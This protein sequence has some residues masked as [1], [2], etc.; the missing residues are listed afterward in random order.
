MSLLK[1][2][3]KNKEWFFSGIG[4]TVF[5]TI[6]QS[7][8]KISSFTYN[9]SIIIFSI[10]F[11]FVLKKILDIYKKRRLLQIYCSIIIN[12][13]NQIDTYRSVL[14][15]PFVLDLKKNY[16][17]LQFIPCISYNK[18]SVIKSKNIWSI[19]FE[20]NDHSARGLTIIGSPGSGK[21]SL[22]K[23]IALSVIENKSISNYR[24]P[25]LLDLY[26]YKDFILKGKTVDKIIYNYF[27][28][29]NIYPTF[30][31]D[32]KWFYNN[33][34]QG[35]CIVLIDGLDQIESINERKKIST[36]IDNQILNYSKSKFIITSRSNTYNDSILNNAFVYEIKQL[37]IANINQIIANWFDTYNNY[38]F[39]G[40]YI[41]NIL[42]KYSNTPKNILIQNIHKSN[43]LMRLS[44]NPL[45]LN[46]ILMIYFCKGSMPNRKSDIYDSILSTLLEKS[47]N[48]ISYKDFRVLLGFVSNNM[49][50]ENKQSFQISD[51]QIFLSKC[52]KYIGDWFE[53][54]KMYIQLKKIEDNSGLI[55]EKEK[56]NWYFAHHT[57]QEYFT[58]LN[59]IERKD[60]NWKQYI[61][62]SWWHN[63][64]LLFAEKNNPS[65]IILECINH[66]SYQSLKLASDI[67]DNI[68]TN[69]KTT[70]KNYENHLNYNVQ[71]SVKEN[72]VNASKIKLH[73]RLN[74]NFVPINDCLEIDKEYITNCE[75]QLFIDDQEDFYQPDHWKHKHYQNETAL[76]PIV[77]VRFSDANKYCRWLSDKYQNYYKFRLPTNKEN[78]LYPIDNKENSIGIWTIDGEC[79]FYNSKIKLEIENKL[80]DLFNSLS[81]TNKH[82][83]QSLSYKYKL[84]SLMTQIPRNFSTF[85]KEG[86]KFLSYFLILQRK[87]YWYNNGEVTI[88]TSD[89][90]EIN[91]L[92]SS[93]FN[94]NNVLFFILSM[95]YHTGDN[96]DLVLYLTGIGFPNFLKS[97]NILKAISNYDYDLA[98]EQLNE[99]LFKNSLDKHSINVFNSLKEILYFII[100]YF[101]E[102]SEEQKNS[103]DKK[104]KHSQYD[105][106]FNDDSQ[107]ED[108][109]NSFSKYSE[110]NCLL[111]NISN[112]TQ[113]KLL[114]DIIQ[115]HKSKS[116]KEI[117][118][119]LNEISLFLA[120]SLQDCVV[121]GMIEF[122]N[123]QF[124]NKIKLN[125]FN[126]FKFFKK[127]G[128]NKMQKEIPDDLIQ[129]YH[130]SIEV[131]CFCSMLKNRYSEK[132]L[133]FE[134][135]RL[136]REKL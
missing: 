61:N 15:Y 36:W 99:Y 48:G 24:I 28:K 57:F 121:V 3:I 16:I 124:N 42:D 90:H 55:I 60:V 79:F 127:R 81:L 75:Y 20:L 67:V 134:T 68:D 113:A 23:Y 136:V 63:T 40:Y 87:D 95:F 112:L 2:L 44:T 91:D 12:E 77:G 125:L 126:I 89:L 108:I 82:L 34:S 130:I 114:L 80:Y 64:L 70:I 88:N 118:Y 26:K 107:L 11:L 41:S 13:Y 7:Y 101:I 29:S 123:K 131:F 37:N 85:P 33:L 53:N 38:S 1:W 52:P 72:Q 27:I 59:W 133:P 43:N 50:I 83:T 31:P 96:A 17:D 98:V 120:K 65:N 74:N 119:N 8:L 54:K 135:I 4:V 103:Y 86:S 51:F 122:V 117:R 35:K 84:T 69:N 92:L 9:V 111:E 129:I 10:F 56:N 5:N 100:F 115:L 6:I 106:I 102:P 94:Y 19:L 32:K 49:M 47:L 62:K 128:L 39:D 25:I 71:E 18:G 109:V 97:D 116:W 45:M 46:L 21:T 104:I 110:N 105:A 93:I 66:N 22:L 14:K 132:V 76:A 58:V 30:S 73:R 78:E